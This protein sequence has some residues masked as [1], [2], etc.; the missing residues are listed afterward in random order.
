MTLGRRVLHVNPLDFVTEMKALAS[1]GASLSGP[2]TRFGIFG[3]MATSAL[4]SLFT[5]LAWPGS[6]TA[7]RVFGRY[8]FD[9]I[10]KSVDLFDLT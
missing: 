6:S 5:A 7:G 9:K 4:F 1:T 2:K 8:V 3:F 10:L